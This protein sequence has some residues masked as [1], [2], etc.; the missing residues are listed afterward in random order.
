[1]FKVLVFETNLHNIKLFYAT[2]YL[3]EHNDSIFYHLRISNDD[4]TL[5]MWKIAMIKLHAT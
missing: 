2:I 3:V 1:M 5:E 4:V